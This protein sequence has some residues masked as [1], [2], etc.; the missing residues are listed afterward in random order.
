MFSN[1][2]VLDQTRRLYKETE[3]ARLA[4]I[5]SI[6]LDLL[7]ISYSATLYDRIKIVRDVQKKHQE[8]PAPK[9]KVPLHLKRELHN[10][11]LNCID[12]TRVR[13]TCHFNNIPMDQFYKGFRAVFGVMHSSS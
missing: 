5:N 6:Q 12:I 13:S 3:E 1:A 9:K 2:C 4:A 8:M 11:I 10:P 7:D